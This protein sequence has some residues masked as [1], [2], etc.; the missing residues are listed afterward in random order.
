MGKLEEMLLRSGLIL[1][2]GDGSRSYVEGS[3]LSNSLV[4]RNS[5]G[6][7]THRIKQGTYGDLL[8]INVSTGAIEERIA[9]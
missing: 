2:N 4:V 1:R 3:L 8:V 5:N 7:I 6:M 9:G